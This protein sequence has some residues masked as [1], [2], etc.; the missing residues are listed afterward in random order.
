MLITSVLPSTAPSRRLQATQSSAQPQ[1]GIVTAYTVSTPNAQGFTSSSAA[2]VTY[3]TNLQTAVTTG[4]FNKLLSSTA[5]TNGVIC[6]SNTT[7]VQPQVQALLPTTSPTPVP[8][9][10][11]HTDKLSTTAIAGITIGSIA[12]VV[13]TFAGLYVITAKLQYWGSNIRPSEPQNAMNAEFVSSSSTATT[14]TT[15]LNSLSS[16]SP[17]HV[18]KITTGADVSNVL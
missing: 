13:I 11:S 1:S 12:F 17:I 10:S 7:A 18:A 9:S 6:L 4:V 16:R 8:T 3:T 2:L 5:T 15:D 14:T